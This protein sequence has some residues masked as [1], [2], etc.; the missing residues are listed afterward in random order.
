MANSTATATGIIT[1]GLMTLTAAL[2]GTFVAG[3]TVTGTGIPGVANAGVTIVYQVTPLLAGEATGGL[4]RYVLSDSTFT[5]VSETIT[6]N[7]GVLTVAGGSPAGFAVG[8]LVNG[9]NVVA[10]TFITQLGTGTGG[11][12]TYYVN[13]NTV[14]SSTA[15]TPYTD[16]ET[17]WYAASQGQTGDLVKMSSWTQG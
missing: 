5:T 1:G 13:N 12:G 14:V 11:A 10:G 4:G 6:A 16:V 3:A 15:I 9:T 2:V 8:T 17:K 7:Y